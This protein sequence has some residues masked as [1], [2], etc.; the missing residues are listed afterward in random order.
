MTGKTVG[1]CC[2]KRNFPASEIEMRHPVVFNKQ[3][4]FTTLFYFGKTKKNKTLS[5]D[6]DDHEETNP[7]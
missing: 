3:T 1:K 2:E 7:D 4:S 5:K 6:N